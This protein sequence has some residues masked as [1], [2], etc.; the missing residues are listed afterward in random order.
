MPQNLY[1]EQTK[2]RNISRQLSQRLQ[3]KM[4]RVKVK[5]DCKLKH[6]R[7][8]CLSPDNP[9]YRTPKAKLLI[10]CLYV[11]LSLELVFTF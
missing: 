8:Q 1:D 7:I 11:F 9:T 5:A 10:L 2:N 3:S 6:H 4:I